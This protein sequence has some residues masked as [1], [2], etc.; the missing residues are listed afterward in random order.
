[1]SPD[2]KYFLKGRE[3]CLQKQNTSSKM[4]ATQ[5]PTPPKP[6]AP[7]PG[8]A[9]NWAFQASDGTNEVFE[10]DEDPCVICHE[11][12]TP[13]TTRTLDCSHRFHDEC[14][15][16]WFKEQST[17]PNCRIHALLPD[18]FPSLK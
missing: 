12:M 11:E 6:I 16:K 8:L 18:E 3:I 14:I 7:P 1:M 2:I 5:R 17:C 10:E 4:S 9:T 15:R 13:T